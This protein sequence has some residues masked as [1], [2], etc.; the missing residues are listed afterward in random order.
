MIVTPH[1]L[2]SQT[3]GSIFSSLIEHKQQERE[4]ENVCVSFSYTPKN[5]SLLEDSKQLSKG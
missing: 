2:A 1:T 4:R 3:E 5:Q